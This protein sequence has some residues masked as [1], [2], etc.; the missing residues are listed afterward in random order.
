[1]TQKFVY[2]LMLLLA[3]LVGRALLPIIDQSRIGARLGDFDTRSTNLII[4]L[5]LRTLILYYPFRLF[6]GDVQRMLDIFIDGVTIVVYLALSILGV[7][8]ARHS[9][10]VIII[11]VQLPVPALFPFQTLPELTPSSGRAFFPRT[12][13]D[14][15]AQSNYER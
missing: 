13:V 2:L 3:D 15:H 7:S 12:V 8:Q 14:K 4:I 10:R 6:L 5:R 9:S 1:M 11:I